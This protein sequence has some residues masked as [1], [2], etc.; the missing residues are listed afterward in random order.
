MCCVKQKQKVSD[1]D[2]CF[3]PHNA[4][5]CFLAP[6]GI[7]FPFSLSVTMATTSCTDTVS[8]G[9]VNIFSSQPV[10]KVEPVIRKLPPT[11]FCDDEQKKKAKFCELSSLAFKRFR[12][13]GFIWTAVLH[14][15]A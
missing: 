10:L 2:A 11:R 12:Q 6:D 5:Y 4:V 3:S 7:V 15:T 1:Q 8:E 9:S 14:I 13:R